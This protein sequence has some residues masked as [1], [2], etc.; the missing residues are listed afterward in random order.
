MF[1]RT[2]T[3]EE[4]DAIQALAN[5][6]HKKGHRILCTERWKRHEGDTHHTRKKSAVNMLLLKGNT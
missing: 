1:R 5:I 4:E 3:S 2:F 6:Q